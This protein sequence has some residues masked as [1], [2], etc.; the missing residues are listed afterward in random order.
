MS[1]WIMWEIGSLFENIG[2]VKDGIGS[3]SVPQVV[4]DQPDATV[5]TVPRGEIVFDAMSFH[6]G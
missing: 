3:I 1:Q 6:Y 4:E 2:T 5:L